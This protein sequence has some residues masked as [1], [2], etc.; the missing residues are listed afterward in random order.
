MGKE[1][2]RTV[3]GVAFGTLVTLMEGKVGHRAHGYR[4]DG[5]DDIKRHVLFLRLANT[6]NPHGGTSCRSENGADPSY[7]VFQYA[8]HE[9]SYHECDADLAE[10]FLD[11]F[12]VE[13]HEFPAGG[14]TLKPTAFAA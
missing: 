8:A 3:L 10:V 2:S 14:S 4:N 6:R 11:G 13:G 7:P 5:K 1:V 12:P 9:G